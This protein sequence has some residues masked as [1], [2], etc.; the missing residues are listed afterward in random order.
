ML[1]TYSTYVLRAD[2]MKAWK[3]IKN[4]LMYLLKRLFLYVWSVFMCKLITIV[5]MMK[6][7]Q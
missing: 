4:N 1:Y 5:Y 7:V 2:M 6:K 3:V